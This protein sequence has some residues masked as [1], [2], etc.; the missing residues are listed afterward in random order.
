MR[1]GEAE[2]ALRAGEPGQSSKPVPGAASELSGWSGT[3]KNIY[4][5][6]FAVCIG[7]SVHT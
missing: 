5:Q 6:I 2:R 1:A 4:V 3:E 7:D